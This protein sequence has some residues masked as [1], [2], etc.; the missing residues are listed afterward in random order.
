MKFFDILLVT[1][2]QGK[3]R[4]LREYAEKDNWL[5]LVLSVSREG[6]TGEIKPKLECL[7]KNS[8]QQLTQLK[9]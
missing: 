5:V 9:K 8:R 4:P 1:L 6:T 7:T 2:A 3:K